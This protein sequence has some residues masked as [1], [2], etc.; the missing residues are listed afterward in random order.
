MTDA[1]LPSAAFVLPCNYSLFYGGSWHDTL[2]HTYLHTVNPA[3]GELVTPAPIAQ[4]SAQDAE[5]AIQ[6]AHEA[7]QSWRRVSGTERA[8]MLR[9]AAEILRE[10]AAELAMLDSLDTGNP[11]AYVP[12]TYPLT[13]S[14]VVLTFNEA[15]R[16]LRM[17]RWPPQ[18]WSTLPA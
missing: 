14:S 17:Q 10:R 4:A 5:A 18:V 9:K 12:L 2:S 3:N 7:F 11:V 16:C 1:K 13:S 15:V 6:A 8:G